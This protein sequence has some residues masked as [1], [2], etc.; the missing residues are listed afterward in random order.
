VVIPIKRLEIRKTEVLKIGD[1]EPESI[2]EVKAAPAPAEAKEEVP[3]AVPE[4]PEAPA[5]EA[6]P[7]EPEEA[8]APE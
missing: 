3:E 4:E 5:E 8:P 6:V 1:G 7:E 2:V